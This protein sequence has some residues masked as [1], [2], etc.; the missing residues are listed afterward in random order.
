LHNAFAAKTSR[1]GIRF[2]RAG[3]CVWDDGDGLALPVRAALDWGGTTHP[4]AAGLGLTVALRAARAHG[5]E[6]DLQ[7]EGSLTECWL[8]VPPR[9]L[10]AQVTK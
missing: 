9:S 2:E 7:R 10:S 3:F 5:F 4:D 1:L 6:L 8:R